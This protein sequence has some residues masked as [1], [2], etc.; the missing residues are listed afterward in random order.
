MNHVALLANATAAL[1]RNKLRSFFMSLGVVL[2][3][4]VLVGVTEIGDQL[5]VRFMATVER[6]LGSDGI[7]VAARGTMGGGPGA[8]AHTLTLA[9]A[10]ALP[11]EIDGIMLADTVQA[12]RDT[13]VRYRNR[14]LTVRVFGS[15]ERAEAAWARLVIS[16]TGITK[17][18]VTES[19]RVALL[20]TTAAERLFG[21]EDPIGREIQIENTPFA[22]KGMMQSIG[23]DG[24][25][26]DRDDEI[27][28][29]ISTMM[30]RVMNVDYL[31][32]VKFK[33]AAGMS[34][35][36]L[37]D[38]VRE[39]LRRRHGIHAGE[40]DDFQVLTPKAVQEMVRQNLSVI[41]MLVRVVSGVCLLV[42]G[43]IVSNITLASVRER[44]RE[45]GLRRAVGARPIDIAAQ[46][47]A[48]AAVVTLIGG[49]AG[50]GL[51]QGLVYAFS[52]KFTAPMV[53]SPSAILT[54]LGAT[55]AVALLA[56]LVPALRAARLDPV[57][58]L[59][60]E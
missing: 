7:I 23:I 38:K 29:P 3:V 44:V 48:E 13:T 53:F 50:I 25:G 22:V 56:G 41:R 40:Q 16:G 59:R 58:A 45:I 18:D 20:G 27:Q 57:E 37:S 15:S 8:P 26:T 36:A 30:H 47:L 14:S 12:R 31:S 17:K 39:V 33:T 42:A 54:G 49:V 46:F 9:E 2:G 60:D 51:A 11:R 5:E 43:M 28:I 24:H 4:T 35:D 21:K 6:L 32:M 55:V 10:E 19:A 34:P 52:V 1:S